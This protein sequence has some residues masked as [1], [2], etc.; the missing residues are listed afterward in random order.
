MLLV[1]CYILLPG[2]P[3]RAQTL[4]RDYQFKNSLKDSLNKGPVLESIN[5]VLGDGRYAFGAGQ[6]LQVESVGVSDQYTMEITF[7]FDDVASWQKII[8]FKKRSSDNGLYVYNGQLQF[9]NFG[10]GGTVQPG[11]MVRVRLEREKASKTVRG[12]VDDQKVFEFVDAADD[13]VFDNE[14]AFFF[15]DDFVTGGEEAPGAVTR[16]RVWDAP[17]GK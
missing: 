14:A 11:Q 4:I 2:R 17:G 16:L 10:I 15:V 13:A 12:F 1:A 8:D 9:Y 3:A 6:G 5:G 7:R